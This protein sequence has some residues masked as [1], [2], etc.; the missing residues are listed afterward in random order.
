M[1]RNMEKFANSAMDF[2][3]RKIHFMSIPLGWGYLVLHER[4]GNLAASDVG[5]GAYKS[6]LLPHLTSELNNPNKPGLEQECSM[7]AKY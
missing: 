2:L 6:P 4:S 7:W 3:C 1:S 5:E